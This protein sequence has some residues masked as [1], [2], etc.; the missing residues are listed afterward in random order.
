MK[1]K[2]RTSILS[3]EDVKGEEHGVGE[4]GGFLLAGEVEAVDLPG[5]PPL[6]EGRGGLVVLESLHYRVVDNHLCERRRGR[7]K[8]AFTVCLSEEVQ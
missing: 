3:A 7:E 5:I 4:G 2:Q 1:K 8:A 6:V